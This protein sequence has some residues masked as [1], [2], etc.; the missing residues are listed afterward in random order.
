M[1]FTK[2]ERAHAQRMLRHLLKKA[3]RR[4]GGNIL[5]EQEVKDVIA[6]ITQPI[7]KHLP[8]K[9]KEDQYKPRYRKI[10]AKP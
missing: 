10:T 9:T 1:N 6:N 4:A 5:T 2:E 8:P 3:K 7:T